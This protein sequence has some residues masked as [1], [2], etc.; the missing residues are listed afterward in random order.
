MAK[1]SGKGSVVLVEMQDN[2]G[3]PA[4]QSVLGLRTRSFTINS[5]VVDVTNANSTGQWREQLG[6]TG[7][8]SFSLSGSGIA[9]TGA[10]LTEINEV[11]MSGDLRAWRFTVTGLGVF[12]GQ[13]KISQFSLAAEYNN[14]VTFDV[15]FEGSG[16]LTFTAT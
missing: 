16:E 1:I 11:A 14:A 4:Y 8:K 5:E 15:T 3:S 7:I 9:D 12:A 13:A 2:A 6:A 10:A